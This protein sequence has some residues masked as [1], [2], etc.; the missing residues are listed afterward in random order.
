MPIIMNQNSNQ[1]LTRN[2]LVQMLWDNI[3]T[4]FQVAIVV[5]IVL[6]GYLLYGLFAGQLVNVPHMPVAEQMRVLGNI[7]NVSLALNA[8]LLVMVVVGIVIYYKDVEFAYVLLAIAALLA[9]GLQY[10]IQYLFGAQA[11]QYVQGEASEQ[12]LHEVWLTG[13]LMGI[14]GLL[15]M[16]W[17]L[18]SRITS[19]QAAEDLTLPVYGQGAAREKVSRPLVG[20]F[21]KCWQLPFCREG[22]RKT[23]PIYHARTKCWKERVGCMCEEN[24]LHLAMS[25]AATEQKQGAPGPSGGFV[26]IGTLLTESAPVEKTHILTR[27]GPRGIRIPDN[28]HLSMAQ[29][30]ERCRNCVIYN[31]HQRHKYQLLA[32]PATLLIPLLVYLNWDALKDVLTN[33]LHGL[34]GIMGHLSFNVNSGSTTDFTRNVTGSVSVEAIIIVCFALIMMTILLRILEFCVFKLKI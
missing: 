18:G 21:A 9:F 10:A 12:T 4:I 17:H 8:S 7:S 26:P 27:P 29:K 2:F 5:S 3:K 15:L 6:Y 1:N 30:R 14:P 31:E 33:A 28:P 22:I 24:I 23:C 11:T 34:D 32:P 13:I 19:G 25:G 16:L 20:A